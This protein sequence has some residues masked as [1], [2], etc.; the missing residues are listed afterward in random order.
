MTKYVRNF[1]PTPKMLNAA[2]SVLVADAKKQTIEPIIK[3]IQR[4][5]LSEM[6]IFHRDKNNLITE[7]ENAWQMSC[8]DF[9]K[10]TTR[11]HG[12]YLT[13]GFKV[14]YG[15]CPLL[16]AD[17]ELREARKQLVNVMESIT[18]LNAIQVLNA[19][20]GLEYFNN[21]VEITLRLLAPFIDKESIA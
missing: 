6:Q 17:N 18:G 7:P 16:I 11:L 15:Y 21:L 12:R 2:Q 4:S 14:K 1:H 3:D 9:G 20:K 13:G 10:Y 19:K 8:A 5:L